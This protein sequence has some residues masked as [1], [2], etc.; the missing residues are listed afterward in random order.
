MA[1]GILEV[2]NYDVIAMFDG[3]ANVG[4][5]YHHFKDIHNPNVGDLDRYN[6]PRSDM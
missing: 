3:D 6:G 4:H 1:A 5:I 2:N